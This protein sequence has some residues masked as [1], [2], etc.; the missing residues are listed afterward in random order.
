M[1]H[2]VDRSPVLLDKA[3]HLGSQFVSRP[4]A[5]PRLYTRE[6]VEG[7]QGQ[8]SGTPTSPDPGQLV[9]YLP[10][11]G[12]RRERSGDGILHLADA[13]HG[14]TLHPG[15]EPGCQF[16]RVLQSGDHIVGLP[17]EG[18]DGQLSVGLCQKAHDRY[19]DPIRV[20]AEAVE[21]LEFRGGGV[22][23]VEE[24]E[25]RRSLV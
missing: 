22:G 16:L 18:V 14:R 8:H 21:Y 5:G 12:R 1:A 11:E 10:G 24:N 25:I 2:K 3:D 15:A 20:S 9:T 7:K 6:L 17:G 19:A 13:V 23:D 4:G